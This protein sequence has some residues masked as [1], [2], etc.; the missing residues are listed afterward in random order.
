MM[1]QT[2]HLPYRILDKSTLLSLVALHFIMIA[3]TGCFPTICI[4]MLDVVGVILWGNDMQDDVSFIWAAVH[5][6]HLICNFLSYLAS[7]QSQQHY[8]SPFCI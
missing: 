7:I 2:A 1:K 5:I 4:T 8:H 3:L 6:C